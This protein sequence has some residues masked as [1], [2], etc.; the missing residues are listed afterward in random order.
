MP[1]AGG[2]PYQPLLC[3]HPTVD[4]P[5]GWLGGQLFCPESKH[6]VQMTRF[7]FK[8]L[9][10]PLSFSLIVDYVATNYHF[11]PCMHKIKN[12]ESLQI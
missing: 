4:G 10:K 7:R 9:E 12:K 3:P 2:F 5:S 11:S 1:A 6:P 8:S